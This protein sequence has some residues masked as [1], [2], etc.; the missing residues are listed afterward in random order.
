MGT[1]SL[2]G[3]TVYIRTDSAIQANQRLVSLYYP[4]SNAYRAGPLH[5]CDHLSS[6]ELCLDSLTEGC[7]CPSEGAQALYAAPPSYARQ[8]HR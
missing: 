4:S 5:P 6:K 8:L 1:R 2:Y 3:V 7:R